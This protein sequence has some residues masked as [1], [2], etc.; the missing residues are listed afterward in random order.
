MGGDEKQA[1]YVINLLKTIVT[2]L[3]ERQWFTISVYIHT[4][5]NGGH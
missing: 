2:N 3:T 4:Y 1:I 5:T